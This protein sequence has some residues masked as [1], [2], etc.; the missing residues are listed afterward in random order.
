[1]AGKDMLEGKRI[2]LVDDEPDVLD[3]LEDL[4]PMCETVKASNFTAAKDY[5]ESEHFDLAILDIM[6]VEGY[7]LLEIAGQREVTAVMLTAHALSP[8]NVVKSYKEGAA[9]YL[10]KEEM[11]NIASFLNDVLEAKELGK[12]PWSRWYDRMGAFFEKKF[13]PK[14]QDNEKDFWEKFPFY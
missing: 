6:G 7:Q 10:P 3:T 9:S 14:W 1:M 13:G 5:L 12:N 11:V 8:E 2:L 4:L